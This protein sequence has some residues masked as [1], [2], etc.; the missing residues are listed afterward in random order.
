MMLCADH[1][2][3]RVPYRTAMEAD[4]RL[5]ARRG[6]GPSHGR[7][8]RSADARRGANPRRPADVEGRVRPFPAPVP[9]MINMEIGN[10]RPVYSIPMSAQ[11]ERRELNSARGPMM[12]R[13]V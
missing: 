11:C 1:E 6:P 5:R 9:G 3:G 8:N 7:S 2:Y 10:E 13:S 12:H 4:T